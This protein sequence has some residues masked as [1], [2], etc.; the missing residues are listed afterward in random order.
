MMYA[1]DK[2]A[3]IMTT[4]AITIQAVMLY[5]AGGSRRGHC[6]CRPCPLPSGPFPLG[7]GDPG[8]PDTRLPVFVAG[9]VLVPVVAITAAYLCIGIRLHEIIPGCAGHCE[10]VRSAIYRR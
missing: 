6:G 8:R 1:L 5:A 2:A 7:P 4:P 3:N 10:F 9:L